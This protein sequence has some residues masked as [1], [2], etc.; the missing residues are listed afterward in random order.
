MQKEK[1]KENKYEAKNDKFMINS[2]LQSVK[3][4][5]SI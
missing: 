4:A 2:K 1:D 5:K 3:S